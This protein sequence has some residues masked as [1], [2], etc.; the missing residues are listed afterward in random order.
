MAAERSAVLKDSAVAGA[1]PK[2]ASHKSLWLWAVVAIIAV[3]AL[4]YFLPNTP[5]AFAA[6]SVQ[7]LA[8]I[9]AILFLSGL[10]SGLSGFGFSAVGAST[11][12][13]MKPV[14]EVPVLQTLSTANQLLS[15]E[16]LREDMPKSLKGFWAG[17]GPC[18]VGGLFGVPMGVWVLAHV[19]A[20]QLIITFGFLLVLY[21]IYSLFLKRPGA[22][23]HG[24]DGP[25]TGA[26][27]GLL[28]GVVGGFT[29]FPGAMVVVWTG[30]RDLP[31][32]MNRAIVQPYIIM[33]Q[34]YSLG[35]IYFTHRSWISHQFWL[36]VLISIP[37]VL[38]GTLG[39]VLIYRRISDVN[40]KR[41]SF[42]LLGL[43]GLG[44]LAKNLPV[45]LKWL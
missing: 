2:A 30:L 14:L 43:S 45:I 16:Q 19:P 37:A 23:L 32:A 21:S 26:A 4:V 28:G 11:L 42:F 8:I 34:V 12:L 1:A 22:K 6:F 38:P 27:V 13:L 3:V 29:A 9:D 18:I 31:K 24:F 41:V 10:M 17:P 20:T 36:M 35:L 25:L 33:S 40:F 7:Q 15:V 44:L 39:G 5:N